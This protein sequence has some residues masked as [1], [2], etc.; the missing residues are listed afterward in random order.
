M[1]LRIIFILLIWI[2][3]FFE[4][5]IS[6]ADS[7][8]DLA[9]S[10]QNPVSDLIS[11]PFQ[12]NINFTVGQNKK[13]QDVLNVQPVWPF[14]INSEW[15]LITRTIIPIISQP[16]GIINTNREFGIGD[17][18]FSA[19][20][21]PAQPQKIIWGIGP[22]FLFP[23]AT[24]RAL[25]VDKWGIGPSVVILRVDSSWVYGALINNIWSFAGSGNTSVN[26]MTL[27]P[28]VNYNFPGGIYLTSSPI[29]TSNWNAYSDERW[30]VP[31]GGGVGKIF[32]VGRQ[33]VNAQV[34][35][36]Y[37]IVKPTFATLWSLRLQLQLLFPK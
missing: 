29:I 6:W 13:A 36:F 16:E 15:N 27:Q 8:E 21:S 32:K 1:K 10:S 4:V 25:G 3:N 2:I 7:N 37:N 9:K 11:I 23:T 14:S 12:N 28:F 19:F 18:S 34:Q 5:C 30:T 22:V 20:L 17:I 31:V 26:L 33:P 35:G 24:H